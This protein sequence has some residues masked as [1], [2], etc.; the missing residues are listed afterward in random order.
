MI[1]DWKYRGIDWRQISQKYRVSKRWFYKLRARFLLEGYEGLR[2][3]VRKN[4]HRPHAVSWQAR[5]RILDYIYNN[6]THGPRRIAYGDP[7]IGVSPTA[8]WNTL[9]KESLNT[10]MKR[11]LWAESQGRPILTKKEHQILLAKNRHIES[12]YAGELVGVDTF[13]VSVANLGRIWQYTACDT[14]SSYG[15]AKV[16][17]DKTSDNS[18]DFIEHLINSCRVGKIKR[19]LTDQGTEFYNSRFPNTESAFTIGLR[20]HSIRHSVTKVAHP[21]TNGYA[22][23][24]NQTIWQEF[25]LGRLDK[26]YAS[27]EELN[28]DLFNFM[29]YYNFRR[30]HSGYKLVR[31][32]YKCPGHAFFDTRERDKIIELKV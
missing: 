28:N 4:H 12:H 20:S 13:T 17:R 23:R 10:R 14:Y 26:R 11:R 8:V 3:R 2:D 7:A 5:L 6:P 21:W 31:E 29:R 27:L 19:I 24:L 25:Y 30:A 18:I 32:G 9:K 15:Y 16:Y 1:D 22:E